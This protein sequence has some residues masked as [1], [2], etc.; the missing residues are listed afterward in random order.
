MLPTRIVFLSPRDGETVG[1]SLNVGVSLSSQ[2]APVEQVVF[3]V[4]DA[5]V[6]TDD[7][8]P[9]ELALDLRQYPA[10]IFTISAIAYGTDT[11]E[12]ARTTLNLIHTSTADEPTIIPTTVLATPTADEPTNVRPIM[13]IGIGLGGLGIFIVMLLIF[14]LVRQQ[15]RDKLQEGIEEIDKLFVEKPL[16]RVFEDVY[17]AP[18]KEYHTPS[19]DAF[20]T[21]V[22]QSSDDTPLIG[23]RFY[24]ISEMTSLGRSAENDI[25]FPKDNPVSR[26]HAEIL[27][28]RGKLF[29]REVQST[30]SA[31][32][33]KSP[34]YGT[35]IN[36]KRVGTELVQLKTGDEIL[37]GKRVRLKFEAGEKLDTLEGGTFDD[38]TV[39][40]DVDRTHTQS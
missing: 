13:L 4:N 37:L 2:G 17:K 36:G 27:L 1:D 32:E 5:V 18:Q 6:G 12:L 34:K 9:Y 16:P 30:D 20:G 7:T 21:L 24:I 29:V 28:Q 26:R 23:H 11:T 35:F 15:Q 19:P 3:Q 10:G 25:N 39:A 38:M 33:P 31:G 8:Q 14:M 22:V 40:D